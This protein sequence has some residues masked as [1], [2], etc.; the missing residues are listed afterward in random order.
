MDSTNPIIREREAQRIR[1]QGRIFSAVCILVI[2]SILTFGCVYHARHTF[3]TARW[4]AAPDA[5]TALVDDLLARY[6]LNGMTEDEILALLGEHD[7]DTGYFLQ[8]NRYV[9]HL[10]PERGLISID[11]EWL[12]LDFTDGVVTDCFITT[13]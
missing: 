2:A 12:I 13:D 3:T 6:P 11:S 4:I 7:N 10:G 8:D 1:R 9:Y 5:R